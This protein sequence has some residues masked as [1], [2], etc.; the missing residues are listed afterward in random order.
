MAETAEFT[1]AKRKAKPITFTLDGDEYTFTPP[2]TAEMVLP[3][4]ETQGDQDVAAL[5]AQFDWLGNGLPDDQHQRLVSRLKD[6]EDDLD[7]DQIEN[8][9]GWVTKQVAGRPT[10]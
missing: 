3:I 4:M 8:V 1:T 6:P 5:K 7:F 10:T 9:L 2:K